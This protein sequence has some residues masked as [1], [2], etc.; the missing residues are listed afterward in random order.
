[1]AAVVVGPFGLALGLGQRVSRPDADE[2]WRPPPT[3][4][5]RGGGAGGNWKSTTRNTLSPSSVFCLLP[6]FR[7]PFSL[8]NSY[9]KLAIFY[10]LQSNPSVGCPCYLH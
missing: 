7:L 9:A 8:Q 3:V 2:Q 6:F 5:V 10:N 4:S 1:M